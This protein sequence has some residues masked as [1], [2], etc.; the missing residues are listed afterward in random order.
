MS[1][2]E[3]E[4]EETIERLNEVVDHAEYKVF[5]NGRIR[6]EEKERIRIKYLNLIV[7]AANSKRSLLKD[8]DLDELAERIAELEEQEERAKYR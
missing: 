7:S 5:G 8:R 1:D 4:R 3:S 6:D 2:I